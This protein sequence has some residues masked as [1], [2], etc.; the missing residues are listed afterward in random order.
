[1]I[2]TTNSSP[3]VTTHCNK[4]CYIYF[5]TN[6]WYPLV[7]RHPLSRAMAPNRVHGTTVF[8]FIIQLFE[9]SPLRSK[10]KRTEKFPFTNRG[11]WFVV[12]HAHINV[13]LIIKNLTKLYDNNSDTILICSI[14]FYLY[15]SKYV[16]GRH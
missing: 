15:C 6:S 3:A 9:N 11:S 5:L 13:S 4:D 16:I 14:C 1:M 10:A 7:T 2:I 8:S 12:H